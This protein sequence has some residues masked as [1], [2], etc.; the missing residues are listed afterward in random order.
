MVKDLWLTVPVG[1]RRQ[2]IDNLIKAS[3]IPKDQIVIVNTVESEPIEGVNNLYDLDEVNIQRWWNKGIKF[4]KDNGARY[5][6]VLNDD[7]ELSDDPLNKIAKAMSRTKSLIGTPY[8]FT[9]NIPGYCWVLDVESDIRPDENYRW[10][11][12]DND[13]FLQAQ[14]SVVTVLCKVRHIEP[15]WQT[16]DSKELMKLT[17]ADA[18]Y[19]HDKWKQ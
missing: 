5:V 2:Y 12:G 18:E 14:G 13:L 1:T 19:F 9:G 10:W 7:L 15:N 17:K 11:F 16:S 8:P 4:A 3:H 6:A